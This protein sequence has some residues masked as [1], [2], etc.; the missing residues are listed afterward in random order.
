LPVESG[1]VITTALMQPEVS[2]AFSL[3]ELDGNIFYAIL[4]V[5]FVFRILALVWVAKDI[6]SRTD[7]V[8]LQVISILLVTLLT[9]IV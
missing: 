3:F 8:Q 1:E 6:T 9:P 2:S 7:N 5:A 4:G